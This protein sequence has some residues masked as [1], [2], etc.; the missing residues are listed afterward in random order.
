MSNSVVKLGI[1]STADIGKTVLDALKSVPTCTV[2]VV[3]SRDISRAERFA[4]AHDIPSWCDYEGMLS[5][6]VDAVYI[7]LPTTLAPDWAVRC[8]HAGK[9]VLVDK[10]FTSVQDIDR[11]L[12]ACYENDVYFMDA[13]HFIHAKRSK[14]VRQKLNDGVIGDVKRVVAAFTCPIRLSGNIR[15]DPTLEPM[16]ALGDLGWYTIRTAV[17]YL[18][19]RRTASIQS[20]SC[21]GKFHDKYRDSIECAEGVVVF[22]TDKEE[23]IS[24]AFTCDMNCCFDQSV[25]IFGTKGKMEVP[26]FI[27]P[28]H[29][30]DY[31]KSERDPTTYTTNTEL[32]ITKTVSGLDSS[33]EPVLMFPKTDVEVI[34]EDDDQKQPSVMFLEFSRIIL[35]KDS[36]AAERLAAESLLTQRILDMCFKQVR[37]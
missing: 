1:L 30:T 10:P 9:H 35:E 29:Q 19:S 18:G 36:A 15:S 22:G 34:E 31:F 17:T 11:M 7:P 3:A 37:K 33:G 25:A 14:I 12:D 6:P 2:T 8:A 20:V 28:Y 24:L 13:T 4:K 21:T 26:G 27:V 16:A 5:Q 23:R 32:I